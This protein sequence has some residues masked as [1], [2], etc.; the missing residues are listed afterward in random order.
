VTLYVGTSGW[1]YRHWR[2]EVFYGDVA[3]KRW[4]PYFAERFQTVEVNNTFYQLPKRSTFESWTEQT[5]NDFVFAVKMS[6]FLTHIKRLK[7]PEEAVGRFF[8]AAAGLGGKLGPVL[9]QMPP[10]FRAD[11]AR[12]DAA[13]SAIA[14]AGPDG[15]RVAVEFRHESWFG[16]EVREVVERHGAALCLAD[17]GSRPIVPVW[18][19][20]DWGYVRFHSG[21]G[22]PETCYGRSSLQRWAERIAGCWRPSEDVY[23][24]FNNDPNGC[25]LRDARVFAAAAARRGLRPT[26]VPEAGDVRVAAA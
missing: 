16:D 11:A 15:L 5:P 21:T 4:L 6:R 13:L 23:V 8:E 10:T 22:K 18:R 20:A 1:Q 9:L 14:A 3:Q 24:Y 26:R 12:L 7:D 17:R 2:R 19:T 25:A